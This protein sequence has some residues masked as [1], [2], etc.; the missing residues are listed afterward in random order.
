MI[1]FEGGD[2]LRQALSIAPAPSTQDWGL[3]L[4]KAVFLVLVSSINEP[5]QIKSN[6]YLPGTAN[7]STVHSSTSKYFIIML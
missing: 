2:V 3:S 4:P 7:G 1:L 5:N 6:Y